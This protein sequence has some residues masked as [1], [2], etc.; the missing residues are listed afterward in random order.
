[1]LIK[2]SPP[3]SSATYHH[4]PQP[5]KQL[6]SHRFETPSAV[7]MSNAG[8][9]LP[10]DLITDNIL[11][12]LSVK[13]LCRFKCVSPL[14][15][16]IIS[17]PRF[18][19]THP[20]RTK[21]KNSNYPEQKIIF[22]FPPGYLTSM[23]YNDVNPTFTKLEFPTE[24]QHDAKIVLWLRVLSSCDGL[25]LVYRC[26][27]SI[28]LLNPSTRELKKPP[29]C[30]FVQNSNMHVV[31]GVGYDSSTDDY[32]V[33]ML[34]SSYYDQS[35]TTSVAM[36]SL[37]TN[38]WRRSEDFQG[39]VRNSGGVFLNGCL[40]FLSWNGNVFNRFIT[41]FDLSGEI[42]KEIPLPTSLV[43]CEYRYDDYYD[44]LVLGG[45]LCLV[46]AKENK[47]CMM[48]EYGVRESW[49]EFTM[50][51]DS[52]E[53]FL[54]DG[55]SMLAEDEF[56]LFHVNCVYGEKQ[57]VVYLQLVVYNPQKLTKRD[58]AICGIPCATV[59]YGGTYVESLVSPFHAGG[60]GR[61]L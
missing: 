23:D 24:E 55:V 31:Y 57:L 10:Q 54:L 17:D 7:T 9:T 47:V 12:R 53:L 38:A 34:S 51:S 61:K 59:R 3:P 43:T 52:S 32:K 15:K 25:L 44:L 19:K 6:L 48:K 56:L 49:T 42:F 5:P 40:H 58:I 1:M 45:S 37:K 60:I 29:V 21:T 50:C 33:V 35:G 30:L 13:S 11:S 18:A 16:S 26:Y 41:A 8:R 28:F 20:N 22:I 27:K 4:P 39:I 14:W 46:S 2:A 36:Y